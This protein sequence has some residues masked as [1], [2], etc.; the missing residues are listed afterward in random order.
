MV[1]IPLKGV[2]HKNTEIDSSNGKRNIMS[3]CLNYTFNGYGF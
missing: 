2:V 1:V 3:I